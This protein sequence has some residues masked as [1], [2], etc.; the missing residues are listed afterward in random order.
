MKEENI[1]NDEMKRKKTVEKELSEEDLKRK[2]ECL[3]V[4]WK[5]ISHLK[6]IKNLPLQ[7]LIEILRVDWCG[8]DKEREDGPRIG[9]IKFYFDTDG[10]MHL[11]FV[12]RC[13]WSVEKKEILQG[14]LNEICENEKELWKEETEIM[15]AKEESNLKALK[16]MF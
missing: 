5:D 4:T 12:H 11:D 15:K 14:I 9:T 6:E 3:D 16:L 8:D 10:A 13:S 7:C 2:F 1:M